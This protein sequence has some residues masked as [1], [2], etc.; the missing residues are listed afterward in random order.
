MGEYLGYKRL[1]FSLRGLCS[2]EK[3]VPQVL[4]LLLKQFLEQLLLIWSQCFKD[5][6]R[7]GNQQQIQLQHATTAVPEN[8][9]LV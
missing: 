7:K 1:K 9:L 2:V 8:F 3:P 5:L 6:L 4:I